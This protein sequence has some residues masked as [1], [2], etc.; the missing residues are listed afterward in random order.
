VPKHHQR[1]RQKTNPLITPELISELQSELS[2]DRLAK[3]GLYIKLSVSEEDLCI[4]QELTLH[5]AVLDRALLDSFLPDPLL[6]E[7]AK[8]WF[9][10][11]NRDFRDAC[12]RAWVKPELVYQVY[13][14]MHKILQGD[15]AKFSKMN[16]VN[17]ND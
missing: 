1:K 9:D 8:A 12:D 14:Q 16:N 5:R 6:K 17:K 10:L 4:R 3:T 15:K 2:L 13:K 11:S 7:D